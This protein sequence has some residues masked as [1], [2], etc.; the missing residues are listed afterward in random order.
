M[1]PN[2]R[3]IEEAEKY[4]DY[5]QGPNAA[6][7]GYLEGLMAERKRAARLVE[8]LEEIA[9]NARSFQDAFK[10]DIALAEYRKAIGG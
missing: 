1:Q 4:A 10:A 6:K 3:D 8:A 7:W 2:P 5:N 9:S